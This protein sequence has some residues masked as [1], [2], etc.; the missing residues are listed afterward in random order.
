MTKTLS[1]D[2][3]PGVPVVESILFKLS[4]DNMDGNQ[5]ARIGR[6]RKDETTR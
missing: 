2:L 6:V 1:E 5:R 4:I 3:M